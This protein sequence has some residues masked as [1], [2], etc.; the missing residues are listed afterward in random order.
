M[1]APDAEHKQI[2]GAIQQQ[3]EPIRQRRE[4]WK[5]RKLGDEREYNE[6]RVRMQTPEQRPCVHAPRW[7]VHPRSEIEVLVS[8]NAKLSCDK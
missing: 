1:S 3:L 4:R 2:G 6:I 8:V 5:E 7:L